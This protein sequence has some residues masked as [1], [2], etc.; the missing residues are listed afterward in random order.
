MPQ[1]SFSVS[2][3]SSSNDVEHKV[4]DGCSEQPRI[5]R[6]TSAANRALAALVIVLVSSNVPS[7]PAAGLFKQADQREAHKDVY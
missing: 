6:T 3:T 1:V 4:E 2:V 5:P 7:I